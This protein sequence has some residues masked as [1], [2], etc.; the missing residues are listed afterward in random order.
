VAGLGQEVAEYPFGSR[1]PCDIADSRGQGTP[2]RDS[3]WIR[4]PAPAGSQVISRSLS[5][6]PGR[7]I[8][9]RSHLAG[10][11][12]NLPKLDCAVRVS[13]SADI[14]VL[15]T[16]DGFNLLRGEDLLSPY[17][18]GITRSWLKVKVSGWTDPEDKFR[19]RPCAGD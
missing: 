14:D 8:L 6:S 18:G 15:N 3:V 10:I 9:A 2:H 1:Y 12:V 11:R 5:G 4:L 16:L 13:D 7:W 17:R 19:R